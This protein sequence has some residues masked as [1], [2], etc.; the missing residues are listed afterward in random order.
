MYRLA[1]L[2]KIYSYFYRLY[3]L[4]GEPESVFTDVFKRWNVKRL[5]YEEDIEP[6]SLERDAVITKLAKKFG[7]E[8]ISK[9]SHTIY[10]PEV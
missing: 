4:R 2:L 3:V 9:V 10:N 5:T 1:T 6:Y 8:I 7:I